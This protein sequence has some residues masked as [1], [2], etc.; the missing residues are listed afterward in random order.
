MRVDWASDESPLVPRLQ[1]FRR[2]SDSSRSA[3]KRHVTRSPRRR[4]RTC[5]GARSRPGVG[6]LR[7]EYQCEPSGGCVSEP[8]TTT[9]QCRS[10]VGC[11]TQA[12]LDR[13]EEDGCHSSAPRNVRNY[14]T[15]PLP[16]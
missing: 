7:Q 14:G 4:A 1:T 10:L 13:V 5:W 12:E 6:V 15:P 9:S 3:K 2:L 16:T 8:S 11:P